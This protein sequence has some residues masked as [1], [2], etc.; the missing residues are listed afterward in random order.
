M[1]TTASITNNTEQTTWLV[2]HPKGLVV[3]REGDRIVPLNDADA[4]VLGLDPSSTTHRIAR[5]GKSDAVAA[6]IA[7]LPAGGP[8]DVL[9][10]RALA[11]MVD[12]DTFGAAGRAMHVLD[13]ASTSQFCGRCGTKTI[14]SEKERVMT[15]P[16]CGLTAYPRIAPAIIVLVRRGEQALLARNAKFPGAFY[17]TLAGFSEIGESLEETLA[18]EVREEV[19]ID[20]R[21][22][23]YFGSQPWPFPHSLMI[24]FTAAWADGEIKVD[25]EEIADAK[26]FSRAELPPIP[27]PLSIARKLIDA[28]VADVT[29]K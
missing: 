14:A 9:G 23:R 26:W 12:A 6:A 29:S 28:W 22:I 2:V 27:P 7:D 4:K 5:A 19:G 11:A 13:W 15:C 17:S 20:V 1:T 3:R 16:A 24:G 10:L 25:G 8:F 18:R 21:D